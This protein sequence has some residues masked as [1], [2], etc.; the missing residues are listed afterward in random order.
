VF[1]YVKR[2]LA[3]YPNL[4]DGSHAHDYNYHRIADV[5]K[6]IAMPRTQ[7]KSCLTALIAV[8]ALASLAASWAS[9]SS[10]TEAQAGTMYNCPQAGK[11][12]ISVWSGERT[13]TAEALDTCG[14]GAV[15]AAYYIQPLI[16]T[17]QVY[18]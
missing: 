13:N 4:L 2:N 12:A 5:P 17:W 16:Q 8:I 6:E 15:D 14:A 10:P 18:F 3:F 9:S 1:S 11:W 7:L